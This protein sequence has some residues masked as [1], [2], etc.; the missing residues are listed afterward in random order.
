M[1][2]KK[3][4]QRW[5]A[6]PTLPEAPRPVAAGLADEGWACPLPTSSSTSSSSSRPTAIHGAERSDSTTLVPYSRGSVKRALEIIQD[7]TLSGLAVAA[8]QRDVYANSGSASREKKWNTW[9]VLARAAGFMDPAHFSKDLVTV[10]MAAL[11]GAGFRSATSYLSIAKQQH[12]AAM[13][14]FTADLALL[15]TQLSRSAKRGLGPNKHTEAL[16]LERFQELP[17]APDPWSALGAVHPRRY[18]I[19]CSWFLL[20]EIEGA[21]ICLGHV[22]FHVE[23]NQ[24]AVSLLLPSQRRILLPP[25]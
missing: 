25:V 15:F 24:Q 19:V 3:V 2:R 12:I 5:F 13:R 20:R 4:S 11:K 23:A 8:L 10:V 9:C 6:P 7:L 17:A 22:S 18:F 21:H 16:P 1:P 14:P